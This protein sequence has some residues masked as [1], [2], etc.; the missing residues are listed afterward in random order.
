MPKNINFSSNLQWFSICWHFHPIFDRLFPPHEMKRNLFMLFICTSFSLKKRLDYLD[1]KAGIHR[2]KIICNLISSFFGFLSGIHRHYIW[3]ERGRK[4]MNMGN[5]NVTGESL[6]KA[7]K[8]EI[9]N[10]TWSCN[11]YYKIYWKIQRN[12]PNQPFFRWDL[13]FIAFG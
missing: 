8:Y 12:Q 5:S 3:I 13:I 1:L 6:F 11:M 10:K 4:N 7:H 2:K 9:D